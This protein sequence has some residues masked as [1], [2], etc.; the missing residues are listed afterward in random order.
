MYF[1]IPP[2]RSNFKKILSMHMYVVYTHVEINME[3]DISCNV[4]IWTRG[5]GEIINIFA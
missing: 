1:M 5:K 2:A 4:R 3:R